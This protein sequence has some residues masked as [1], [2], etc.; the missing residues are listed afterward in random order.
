MPMAAPCPCCFKTGAAVPVD[1]AGGIIHCPHCGIYVRAAGPDAAGP[2][3]HPKNFKDDLVLN[4][5]RERVYASSFALLEQHAAAAGA[6][7]LDIG[8]G[9]GYFLHLLRQRGWN[10]LTGIDPSPHAAPLAM[11]KFTIP[12]RTGTVTEQRFAGSS[13]DIIT[14]WDVLDHMSTPFEDLREINRILKPGGLL[15]MRV[16]NMSYHMPARRAV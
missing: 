5:A 9:D 13:F 2:G 8:A 10:Y 7:L 3:Q 14:L 16:R 6:S 15:L 1:P 4:R 12:L 11:R